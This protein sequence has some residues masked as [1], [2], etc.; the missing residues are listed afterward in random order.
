MMPEDGLERI[1]GH[2]A[3]FLGAVGWPAV[4]DH[5][6]LWGLLIP[7][8]REFDQY[9]NLR[10]VRLL[11]VPCPLAGRSPATSTSG[12]CA[13]T[14]KANIPRSAAGSMRHGARDGHSAERVHAAWHR[15]HS[16]LR[17]RAG[18]RGRK[19]HLTSA[20]KS[21]GIIHTMPYWDERFKAMARPIRMSA[22]TSTTS[23]F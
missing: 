8:R 18:A 15:P 23:T 9:V 7:I 20:T 5:V 12:S 14:T 13:R 3:I 6:S 11:G 17:L 16:A 4:P 22:S 19:K 21:N 10:P 2:D 1:A